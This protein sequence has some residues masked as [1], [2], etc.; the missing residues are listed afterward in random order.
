[1]ST[2]HARTPLGRLRVIE[3]TLA[4]RYADAIVHRH[5]E[6]ATEIFER[7]RAV[8]RTILLAEEWGGEVGAHHAPVAS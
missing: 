7:R 2:L 1:M 8:R 5:F 6:V 3:R 4:D